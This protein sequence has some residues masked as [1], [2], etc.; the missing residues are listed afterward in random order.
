MWYELLQK[1]FPIEIMGW[2]RIAEN[3]QIEAFDMTFKR[4]TWVSPPA[5]PTGLF[6]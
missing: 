3:G 1:S 4:W 6:R 2:Y 5:R